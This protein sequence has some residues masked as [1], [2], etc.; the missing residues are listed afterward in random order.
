[1]VRHDFII[2][3]LLD[4]YHS[5][6]D[7]VLDVLLV[8]AFLLYCHLGG[9]LVAYNEPSFVP[10]IHLLQIDFEL[11]SFGHTIVDL[12]DL[13]KDGAMAN[14][15]QYDLLLIHDIGLH[16]LLE[17]AIH[18]VVEEWRDQIFEHFDSG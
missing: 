1:M 11:E 10:N 7:Q 9:V 17:L 15:C 12:N 5:G 13:F 8:E 18:Y 16:F 14:V 4:F 3:Y 2:Y 6:V